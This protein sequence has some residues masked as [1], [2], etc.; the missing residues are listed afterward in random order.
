M[1]AYKK[2][3]WLNRK[4][5]KIYYSITGEQNPF[6]ILLNGHT[7]DSSDFRALTRKLVEKSF[8]VINI[9]HRGC[10]R[11]ES[12]NNFS[13][14]DMA[15]DVKH[16]IYELE[17]KKTHLVGVSMGGIVAQKLASEP[18]YVYDR[19]CLIS[20]TSSHKDLKQTP[21]F[22]SSNLEEIQNNLSHYFSRQFAEK[23]PLFIKIMSQQI[24][25]KILKENFLE[26]AAQQKKALEE[27]VKHPIKLEKIK[28]KTL[29]IHGSDD[30]IIL[31]K[32]AKHLHKTI[33]ESTLN[34]YENHG[35]L[36]LAECPQK[37]YETI[38]SFLKKDKL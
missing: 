11:T 35:H 12:S 24:I 4:S 22:R 6:V 37:L 17:I 3:P 38:I 16:L 7:R 15:D 1:K 32:S 27:L 20:T 33:P 5:A 26:K 28:A 21:V 31:E 25:K 29:I 9:D 13:L 14:Q 2:M 30:E 19:L 18:P 36:L 23:N 8:T 10:G 34:L